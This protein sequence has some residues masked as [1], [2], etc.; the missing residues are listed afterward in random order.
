MGVWTQ[1]SDE[2]PLFRVQGYSI[3]VTELLLVLY[4]GFFVAEALVGSG[5]GAGAAWLGSLRLATPEVIGQGKVWQL[6]TYPLINPV[7]FWFAGQMLVLFWCG[8][9]VEQAIGRRSFLFLYASLVAIPAL[10][11]LGFSLLHGTP[12]VAYGSGNVHLAL[13]VAF[14]MLFPDAEIYFGGLLARW[15]AAGLVAIQSLIDISNRDWIGLAMLSCGVG[16]A[17]IGVHSPFRRVTEWLGEWRE[18]GQIA[19]RQQQA[20]A[21]RLVEEKRNQSIDPILEKISRE[22]L[23]SL[24]RDERARLERARIELL[25]RDGK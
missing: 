21:R 3:R 20:A 8:R 25:K 17:A 14:A 2:D 7:N 23:P 11:L 19:R 6:L 1:P 22:G 24:T 13:F 18:R 12:V 15:V 5:Q 10:V 4:I 9:E 16:V